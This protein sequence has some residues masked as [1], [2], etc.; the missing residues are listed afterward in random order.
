MSD[1]L[2]M[3]DADVLAVAM[4]C[5]DELVAAG[6]R[7]VLLVGSHARGDAHA[8]S[9]IDLHV[10]GDGPDYRLVRREPF[11][12]SISWRTE[13][14]HRASFDDIEAVGGAI[15][16]WRSAR[17]LHDR[18]SVA[19]ALQREARAWT[20]ESIGDERLNTFVADAVHGYAEEVHKLVAAR[21]TGRQTT[22]A[23][24]RSILA[25]RLAFPLAVHYRLLFDTENV[26]WDQVN[27]AM[28]REWT[29]AQRTALGIT[30]AAFDST[31]DAALRMFA[32]A[33]DAVLEHM[34]DD[35]RAVTRHALIAAGFPD[36]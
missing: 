20:W 35:Q 18:H 32:L 5:A 24:Q 7:A 31:C 25:L 11:L 2:P 8:E 26:L 1:R 19:A 13:E 14:Q 4:T 28:G 30:G 33:C 16:A 21:Q 3:V 9:D 34:A 27:D 12:V 10:I 23:V 22:A 15:P 6:A 17:I 36:L 29:E